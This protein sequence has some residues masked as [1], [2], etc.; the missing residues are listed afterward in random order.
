[1]RLRLLMNN[2]LWL[3][4]FRSTGLVFFVTVSMIIVYCINF[5]KYEEGIKLLVPLG[6][7]ISAFIASYSIMVSIENTKEIEKNKQD[8]NFND[9]LNIF[10][11]KTSILKR[12]LSLYFRDDSHYK[13][14]LK[15]SN[16]SEK[17]MH[18]VDMSS[19]LL[20]KLNNYEQFIDTR[21]KNILNEE[22]LFEILE[23]INLT[24]GRLRATENFKKE[25][26]K[27]GFTV[28]VSTEWSLVDDLEKLENK[29]SVLAKEKKGHIK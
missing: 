1:M 8:K 7:L 24:I 22:E 29:L 20:D 9:E 10:R 19:E 16:I 4:I 21:V 17:C 14:V 15:S 13:E 23:S 26:V 6:V 2:N 11:L 5:D 25:P 28:T 12:F 27:K 3:K 18:H